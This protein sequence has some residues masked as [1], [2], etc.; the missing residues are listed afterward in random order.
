M[1]RKI[2]RFDD[3]RIVLPRLCA[4]HA[5]GG[6]VGVLM[7]FIPAKPVHQVFG[8]HQ[9]IRHAVEP[10]GEFVGIE[11]IDRI[12]RLKLNAG[13]AIQF[14]K[15]HSFVHL[16]DRRFGTAVA[17]CIDRIDRLIVFEQYVIHAPGIDRK[18]LD[19]I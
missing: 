19:F 17:V 6:G 11:L 12:E 15:R 10:P 1:C 9:K 3:L 16:F 8:D 7:R 2:K 18:R 13:T 4:D 5:G 14:G